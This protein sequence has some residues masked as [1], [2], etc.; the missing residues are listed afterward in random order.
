MNVRLLLLLAFASCAAPETPL[1]QE[2]VDEGCA[3]WA[4][5]QPRGTLEPEEL[6]EASGLAASRVHDDVYFTHNDS[7]GKPEIFGLHSDGSLAG[8]WRVADEVNRDWEAIAAGPCPGQDGDCLYVGDTGDNLVKQESVKIIV[9]REPLDLSSTDELQP[10]A[11]L[12]LSY[13][14]GA[15]DVEALFVDA[16]GDL[17]LIDKYG[18]TDKRGVFYVPSSAFDDASFTAS[19][20]ATLTLPGASD[21]LVTDADLHPTRPLLLVRTYWSVL[22]YEGES[23]G[24][25][26]ESEALYIEGGEFGFEPQ[27]EAIAWSK[28]GTRFF[29]TSETQYATVSEWACAR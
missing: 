3:E 12:D 15:R 8:R 25:M 2:V 7:G 9:V 1:P 13:D 27:G 16:S 6:D 24:E 23:I 22:A 20:V 21:G 26:L 4:L 29:T 5:P 10:I 28:D 17:Y 14:E 11:V 18:E 19:R